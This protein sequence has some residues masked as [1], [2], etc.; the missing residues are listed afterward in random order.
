MRTSRIVS[1]CVVAGAVTV[2]AAEPTAGGRQ[3]RATRERTVMVTVL[4]HA[5][6][7]VAGLGVRDF[8]VR[9][10]DVAREVL[11]VGPA[12]DPMQ[13]A[14]LVDTSDATQA[15]IP[16]LRK[17]LESAAN[18]ILAKIP[19]SQVALISFGERPTVES[20]YTPNIATL[21]R[22]IQRLFAKPGSGSYLLEAIVEAT[23]GLKK[24]Q[25]T[26]PVIVAFSSE[27]APEFSNDSYQRVAEVLRDVGAELWAIVLQ[28]RTRP[29][30]SD[31]E[32]NRATVLGDVTAQ[33]G[34]TRDQI[35]VRTALEPTYVAVATRL[36]S[37]YAITYSRPDSLIAPDR[38]DVAITREGLQILAPRWAGK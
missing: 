15:D 29:P 33:S 22:T 6:Q 3:T 20:D 23:Q 27:A 14:L 38:L 36:T 31:A 19:Q 1:C 26:R 35:L 18:T 8:T 17:G 12:T 34:G 25:A 13:V 30:S 7:S 21:Q 11:R 9:E 37:Q 2:L 4:D 28:A 32:R 5:G 10:N 24:H 16:D